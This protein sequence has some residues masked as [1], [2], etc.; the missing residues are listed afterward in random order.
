MHRLGTKYEGDAVAV[1]L[2]RG[3]EEVNLPAVVLA[4][5]IAG[6]GPPFLGV[7]PMRDDPEPGVQVRFVYPKSPAEAAGLK[8][9]YPAAPPE[10]AW[11]LV[12]QATA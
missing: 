4:G 5:V 2:C 8:A 12:N 10:N 6:G 3:K 7:L 9:G 11:L 1:K